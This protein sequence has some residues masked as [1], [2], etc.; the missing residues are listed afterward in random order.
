MLQTKHLDN[1]G[2]NIDCIQFNPTGECKEG[3]LYF[4]QLK[5]L[6]HYRDV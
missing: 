4:T 1:T 6:V 5:Y 3:G 2:L